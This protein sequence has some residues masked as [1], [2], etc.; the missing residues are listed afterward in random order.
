MRFGLAALLLIAG[1]ALADGERAGD[2]D[3]Y[4]LSLGWQP[5]W[6]A[7]TGDARGAAECDARRD[8]SF[9]LH[10]LW[11]Q[12]ELGWPSDCRSHLPDATRRE[13]AGMADIMGSSSLAWHEWKKHGRCAGLPAADYFARSRQAYDSVRLPEVFRHL[14]RDIHLPASVVEDAFIEANPGLERNMI[15]VTCNGGRIA[16]IRLCLTRDLDPRPCGEDAIR[17]CRI[18]DA[19]MEK[20]R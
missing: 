20:P 16:E 2:F 13:T 5:T 1:P 15:T 10:G 19:L 14:A 8:R 12:Y 3:Y 18:K 6:C 7:L 17:D 11:P 4:V 9:T